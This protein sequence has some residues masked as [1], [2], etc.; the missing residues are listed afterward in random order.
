MT[1]MRI[2]NYLQSNLPCISLLKCLTRHTVLRCPQVTITQNLL[3]VQAK[4]PLLRFF[5]LL[6]LFFFFLPLS[7]VVNLDQIGPYG[8]GDRCLFHRQLF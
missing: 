6:L 2:F 5:L 8:L 4:S 3:P 1:S 7:Y